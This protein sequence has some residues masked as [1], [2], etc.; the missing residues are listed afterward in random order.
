MAKVRKARVAGQHKRIAPKAVGMLPPHLTSIS[1]SGVA[2]I[3][4][5]YYNWCDAVGNVQN[6]IYTYPDNINSTDANSLFLDYLMEQFIDAIPSNV[7]V[8]KRILIP[9][10]LDLWRTKG[11]EEGVKLLFRIMFDKEPSISYPKE[12]ILRSSDGIWEKDTH[13]RLNFIG[14]NADR[15]E[16]KLI[17]GQTSGARAVVQSVQPA[18]IG[19]ESDAL[20]VLIEGANGTFLADE[21]VYTPYID[22][23]LNARVYGI[24][25]SYQ[26]VNAGSGYEEGDRII[27]TQDPVKGSNISAVVYSV[28]FDGRI[29]GISITNSGI[30]YT[31]AAPTVIEIRKRDSDDIAGDGQAVIQFINGTVNVGNGQ[32]KAENGKLSSSSIRLQNGGIYQEFSYLIRS[33]VPFSNYKTVLEKTVHPAG[34]LFSGEV[35]IGPTNVEGGSIMFHLSRTGEPTTELLNY[36]YPGVQE[37][38]WP[39]HPSTSRFVEPE[40]K[41]RTRPETT[42]QKLERTNFAGDGGIDYTRE[43]GYYLGLQIGPDGAWEWDN[44]PVVW[45][46][47]DP[48]P[49]YDPRDPLTNTGYMWYQNQYN[50]FINIEAFEIHDVFSYV[51]I[52]NDIL[53]NR[54]FKR[55]FVTDIVGFLPLFHPVGWYYNQTTEQWEIVDDPR[56]RV[57]SHIV[58]TDTTDNLL[59]ENGDW[60]LT[61]G[62]DR[63]LID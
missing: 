29:T 49:G 17:V 59:A 27:T 12:Q 13:M 5:A 4:R 22:P 10:I 30:Q 53:V 1:D 52:N 61:E 37:L 18:Q 44:G 48:P 63:I 45:P 15:L 3:L 8:D 40:I 50:T 7:V 60:L 46:D 21:I 25:A 57:W 23:P 42:I 58:I 38:G 19:D 56:K 16:G 2:E 55:T 24:T 41:I 34:F 14:E 32:W 39:P 35:L 43:I 11:T 51:E 26:I 62:G 20:Y 28:D 9:H 31:D 33:E 6:S 54:F 47:D 36:R